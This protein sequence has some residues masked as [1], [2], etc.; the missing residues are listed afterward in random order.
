MAAFHAGSRAMNRRSI[1]I[2]VVG[3]CADRS[4]WTPE[5]MA[6]LVMLSADVCKRH[7]IPI[8]HQA[9]PGVCGHAD[10]VDPYNPNLRGGASHHH[11]PGEFFPWGAF[12]DALRAELTSPEV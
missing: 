7:Q 2:E 6:Q 9:G 3:H 4:L 8:L 1:G 11:D 5:I 12:L 10:V